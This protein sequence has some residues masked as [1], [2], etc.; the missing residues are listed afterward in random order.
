MPVTGVQTCALPISRGS[1]ALRGA[2]GRHHRRL[3]GLTGLLLFACMFLPAVKGCHEPVVPYEVPPFLPPYFYGL[4]FALI[5]IARSA[6]AGF[7]EL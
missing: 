3:T 5:A 6:S 7:C 2:G 1:V 4:V